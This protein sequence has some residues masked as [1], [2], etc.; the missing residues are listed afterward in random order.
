MFGVFLLAGAD[1]ATTEEFKFKPP[2]NVG[3]PINSEWTERDPYITADGQKLF[4]CSNRP[5]GS[6]SMDVWMSTWNGSTWGT[7]VNCGPNV[8]SALIEWSP[9]LSLDGKKLY[10]NAFGR[11]GS[12]G[13]WDVWTSTWDSVAQQWGPAQNLGPPINTVAVDWCPRLSYN[14]QSLYYTTNGYY[15]PQGSAFFVSHWNGS[16]WDLPQ[17]LPN[18]I[19]NTST[20]ERASLTLDEKTMYFGRYNS[21]P[22]IF[23]TQKGMGGEWGE[24]IELDTSI[25]SSSGTGDPAIT[26]DGRELYFA[27]GRS[28]GIGPPGSG[29]IWVAERIIVPKVSTLSKPLL[30]FTGTLLALTGLYWLTRKN[31]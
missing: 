18:I 28:G 11:P 6:G 27:S 29:D 12:Q 1:S 19:N 20:E 8:N 21:Y 5:G 7:P 3:P 10:F 25:N 14:G 24:P 9:S 31:P 16:S 4:F 15:H 23:V 17:P 22:R 2:V 26:P 13:G 30:F